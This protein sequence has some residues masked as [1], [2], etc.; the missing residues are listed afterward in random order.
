[1]SYRGVVWVPERLMP[2]TMT[3]SAI[4]F[5]RPARV[6]ARKLLVVAARVLILAFLL[7][8]VLA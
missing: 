8:G 6:D 5:R 4:D 2:L 1:M 7:Y 3:A